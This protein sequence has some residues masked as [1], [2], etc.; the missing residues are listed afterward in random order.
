[1][2]LQWSKIRCPFLQTRV[3]QVQTQEETMELRLPE[4][5]P[6]IGR[7]LCAWGSCVI[8][9]KQWR[10]DSMSVSGGVNASV[11]YVPEDGS[12]LRCVQAWLPFQ[13]KWSFPQTHRECAIRVSCLLRGIDARILS[14]RKMMLRAN[15]SMLGQALETMEAEISVPEALP[16]GVEVLTNVYPTVLPV[17][18]GEKQFQFDDELHIPD[19]AQWIHFSLEPEVTEQQVVGS[20]VVMRGSALLRYLYLDQQGQLRTGSKEI[21]FAQF[22][23]LD[24]D[25]EDATV[26]VLLCVANLEPEP[27][28]D[29]MRIGCTLTAQYVLKR[30][31]LLE[32][33]E[34]AYSTQCALSTDTEMLQLPV[35]LDCRTEVLDL[36][37]QFREGKVLDLAVLPEQPL[38]YREGDMLRL[39]VPAQVRILYED[40]DGTL[41][42][43]S[44]HWTGSLSL[45]SADNTQVQAVI[46]SVEITD[47]TGRIKLHLQTG[48]DQ[49]IPM[50]QALNLGERRPVEENR[51]SLILRR[52]DEESLWELAK[53]SGSTMEAIRKANGLTKEPQQ[54]QM[55][56]IPVI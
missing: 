30:R 4:E 31:C 2:E 46:R 41:Q 47:G 17:E 43:C 16:G 44:Q 42:T 12:S 56:L 24:R 36:D 40:M 38:Q 9:S 23:D 26:D 20:R 53:Q 32:I 21:P 54:G 15:I 25:Y 39:E 14:A 5:L 35:E 49:Q 45:P 29:G 34:D 22:A 11:L 48:A 7:V 33:V 1:M 28:E 6:D 3:H 37:L 19:V 55:L 8:R 18:A 52:M 50:I 13:V 51:P 27:M 10:G